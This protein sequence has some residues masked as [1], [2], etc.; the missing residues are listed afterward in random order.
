M[1]SKFF[2]I[3]LRQKPK[4]KT[5]GQLAKR[6]ILLLI[7]MVLIS[8]S[9]NMMPFYSDGT[10][11]NL[12]MGV[13][14]IMNGKGKVTAPYVTP[15]SGEAL[16][17]IE[18][19]QEKFAHN[20]VMVIP[21]VLSKLLKVDAVTG[22]LLFVCL[23]SAIYNAIVA[24]MEVPYSKSEKVIY[25]NAF[26]SSISNEDFEKSFVPIFKPPLVN[27]IIIGTSTTLIL[28]SLLASIGSNKPELYID[29]VLL[30]IF[31]LFAFKAFKYRREARGLLNNLLN[32]RCP[33]CY[34][35]DTIKIV[36]K[37]YVR[38]DK[39]IIKHYRT[40]TFSDGSQKKSQTGTSTK[41]HDV[42]DYTFECQSC[43]YSFKR[44]F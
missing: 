25:K 32:R 4:D 26:D 35:M 31:G 23:I 29:P 21:E 42:H 18:N 1:L 27:S 19:D 12:A 20:E 30:L 43:G 39:T 2:S 5:Y 6:P 44:S 36:D 14:V 10:R 11:M 37:Q 15:S 41:T 16:T 24:A 8:V 13:K 7:F 28:P 3:E 34:E 22:I 9:S 38:T 40:T 17:E 33:Q